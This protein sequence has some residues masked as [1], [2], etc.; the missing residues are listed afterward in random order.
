M[1]AATQAFIKQAVKDVAI[2]AENAKEITSVDQDSREL[3]DIKKLLNDSV[4]DTRKNIN[5]SLKLFKDYYI[6]LYGSSG[7]SKWKKFNDNR[8]LYGTPLS[9]ITGIT[10][11]SFIMPNPTIPN[12]LTFLK[13][14]EVYNKT[15]PT[16]YKKLYNIYSN[17]ADLTFENYE[18]LY[19]TNPGFVVPNMDELYKILNIDF[20]TQIDKKVNTI[21]TNERKT[22]YERQQIDK[23]KF[24]VDA[25]RRLYI[26]IF[27]ILVFIKLY[28][29]F[30]KNSISIKGVFIELFILSF[31]FVFPIILSAQIATYTPKY[32]YEYLPANIWVK[33]V[34]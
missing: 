28:V 13:K 9:L 10:P 27:L 19:N 5:D 16:F 24:N 26:R 20:K 2:S 8:S 29:Y 33:N 22:Y 23:M 32:V 12:D 1:S 21:N 15:P 25:L 4:T 6:K 7:V 31:L 3:A 17:N 18:K 30:L 11:N 34:E 14:D